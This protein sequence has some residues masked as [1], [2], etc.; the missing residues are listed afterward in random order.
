LKVD[1]TIRY[2]SSVT[3]PL[4]AASVQ[5]EIYHEVTT[6]RYRTPEFNDQY[7][8][9]NLDA[10]ADDISDVALSGA[11]FSLAGDCFTAVVCLEDNPLAPTP[12][13]ILRIQQA[14][15]M[16]DFIDVPVG[17]MMSF[18]ILESRLAPPP[19]G[20]EPILSRF[21]HIAAD[22]SSS[23]S[24]YVEGDFLN[25]FRARMIATTPGAKLTQVGAD[26][27]FEINAGITDAWV[28]EA[29]FQGLFFTVF[30]QLKLMFAA[31]F[32]FDTELP[33]PEA[34]ATV[35]M[36]SQRWVTALG[37]YNHNRASLK[38]EM[39][40]GGRFNSNEGEPVQDTEYGTVDVEFSDCEHGLVEF[41]F[42]KAGVSGTFNIE[43]ALS[44]KAALCEDLLGE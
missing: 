10:S 17:E 43:R 3:P 28:G 27:D 13:R 44:E 31:W 32:T 36:P 21:T 25:S 9:I 4:D 35:G 42:P 18:K 24:G 26:T 12:E 22:A 7:I 23:F 38:A 2:S 6:P 37:S 33:P 29:P 41:S 11:L 30:P 19:G 39:T 16:Y 20:T 34:M 14:S 40:M 1:G 8:Q 15:I 5:L